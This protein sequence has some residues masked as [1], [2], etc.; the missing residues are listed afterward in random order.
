MKMMADVGMGWSVLPNTMIDENLQVLPVQ[1][2][3]L[4][5]KLG[6]ISYRRKHLSN[7]AAAFIE[8]AESIWGKL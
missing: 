3:L 5:R 6:A 4:T 7:A 2:P 1:I 8:T